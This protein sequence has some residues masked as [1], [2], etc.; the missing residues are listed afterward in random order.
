MMAQGEAGATLAQRAVRVGSRVAVTARPVAA[1]IVVMAAAGLT[2]VSLLAPTAQTN[3]ATRMLD[4]LVGWL[5]VAGGLVIGRSAVRA[6]W[7]GF[8]M[9][10]TGIGWLAGGVIHRGPLVHLLLT[11]PAG[12]SRP[13]RLERALI[14]IAYA[15][16]IVESVAPLEIATIGLCLGVGAMC[17]RALVRSSGQR[18][19]IRLIP[20]IS[21]LAISVALASV[22]L[23]TRSGARLGEVPLLAYELLL[24]AV[25]LAL[26]ADRIRNVGAGDAVTGLVVDL[27]R[28]P[29]AGSLR[30]RL[31]SALG[32]PSLVVGYAFGPSGS[33]I[34]E[35]G[36]P[37][38][39]PPASSGRRVTPVED[40]GRVVAI[41]IHDA[42]VLDEPSLV[43]SV[44]AA[45]RLAV[46]NVRHR[47]EIDALTETLAASQR[48]IVEAADNQRR[49]V[50]RALHAGALSRLA[51]VRD[52]T[53]V[54]ARDPRLSSEAAIVDQQLRIAD[55]EFQ[56]FARGAY[57]A[58]L[59]ELGLG[60]AVSALT[61]QHAPAVSIGITDRRLPAAVE[62]AAYFV[63]A[64][65]LANANKHAG[66]TRVDVT[67]SIIGRDLRLRV[68]D[69]GVGGADPAGSGLRGLTARVAAVGGRLT[70]T[71]P[72]GVG[73]TV[74]ADIPI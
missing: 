2:A 31:A 14:A 61:A 8:L 43:G 7:S 6:G 23:L 29:G 74:E 40:H 16:G 55:A 70:I 35:A 26:V 66:A 38:G 64:E 51:R 48:R 19:R 12:R 56:A 39:L 13:G 69:D 73:T 3:A 37:V 1:P 33:F 54:A 21:G 25:A 32:D 15:D 50:E 45:T 11:D 72:A 57:P 10:A 34:D 71:S 49:R 65:A 47:A 28:G 52:L 20:S 9:V 41:L 4:P 68:V 36:R 18:R 67:A 58:A 17:V 24:G 59:S 62:A 42:A 44:G 53:S 27:G 46:E 22:S 5:F 63:C 30:D 60:A